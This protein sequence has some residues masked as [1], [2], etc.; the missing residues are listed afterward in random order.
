MVGVDVIRTS[1]SPFFARTVLWYYR[2][3]IAIINVVGCF[4]MTK[5]SGEFWFLG[6][7]RNECVTRVDWCVGACERVTSKFCATKL[8]VAVHMLPVG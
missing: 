3:M 1:K 6:R 7:R 2:G 8:N 5:N 4:S